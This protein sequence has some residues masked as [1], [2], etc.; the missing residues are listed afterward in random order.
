VFSPIY[1][2]P[3]GKG[4]HWLQR[5]PLSYIVGGWQVAMIGTLQSGSPFGV[6]VL[7]GPTNLRATIP[8]A[9]FCGP[10]LWLAR[11]YTL[12]RKALRRWACGGGTG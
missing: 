10:T 7:N 3:F 8:T 4:R 11:C 1:D 9:Q 5:G 12:R 2:M 6:S